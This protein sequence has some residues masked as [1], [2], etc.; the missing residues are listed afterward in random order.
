MPLFERARVEVYLP[1]L[2]R[3]RYEDLLFALR[4]EFTHTFGAAHLSLTPGFSPVL[5]WQQMRNRFNGFTVWLL[6]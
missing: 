4:Q 1:D 2:P 3:S 6:T 5:T